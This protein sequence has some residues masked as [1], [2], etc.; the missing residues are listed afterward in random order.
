MPERTPEVREMD[1]QC[2]AAN[3]EGGFVSI[4]EVLEGLSREDATLV[5]SKR[6]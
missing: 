4:D 3:A 2:P 1:V 5:G 6:D